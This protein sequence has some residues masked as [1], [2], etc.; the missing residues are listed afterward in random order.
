L[1]ITEPFAT[2]RDESRNRNVDGLPAVTVTIVAGGVTIGVGVGEGE[3]AL[4]AFALR[5]LARPFVAACPNEVDTR[6]KTTRVVAARM[7]G[8]RRRIVTPF[9]SVGMLTTRRM[10]VIAQFSWRLSPTQ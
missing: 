4:T 10:P 7:R 3:F 8:R 5:A 1:N 9:Q 6:S 2:I